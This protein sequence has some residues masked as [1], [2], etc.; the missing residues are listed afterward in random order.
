MN[1][2]IN[3]YNDQNEQ[4]RQELNDALIKNMRCRHITNIYVLGDDR[5]LFIREPDIPEMKKVKVIGRNW[6]NGEPA[7]WRPRFSD[8]FA[9]INYRTRE[10][11]INIVANSDVSFDDTLVHLIPVLPVGPK[12]CALFSRLDDGKHENPGA[13]AWAFRG[14]I[15]PAVWGEFFLGIP[16]CDWRIFQ[17]LR[18]QRYTCFNPSTRINLHHHHE[19]Q[20]RNWDNSMYVQ[21]TP[22]GPEYGHVAPQD[23]NYII[24]SV[25]LLTQ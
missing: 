1:L 25:K 5:F 2:W 13:D 14:K 3:L 9:E 8:F 17:E 21:G 11:E 12:V 19:S 6:G 15:D 20:V 23:F 4:R 24:Q 10:N 16:G 22:W 7:S 18:K